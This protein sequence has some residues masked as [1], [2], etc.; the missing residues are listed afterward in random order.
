MALS[1]KPIRPALKPTE[2]AAA[3]QKTLTALVVRLR[4]LTETRVTHRNQQRLVTEP[5]VQDTFAAILATLTEQIRILET[6]IAAL[7]DADPIWTQLDEAFRLIK[8][9]ADRTTAGIMAELPEI[10]TISNKAIAKL[11]GLA[12][13]ANDSGK[14]SGRRPIR[15][16]RASVRSLL[17]IV[18]DVVRR[19]EPD[20][21]WR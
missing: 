4:Q 12:P 2:P 3:D 14:R 17:F 9:V 11:A 1:A 7:I 13:I 8:G 18:A 21:M 19:H 6:A 16:G 20:F 15:G 5:V 10:G